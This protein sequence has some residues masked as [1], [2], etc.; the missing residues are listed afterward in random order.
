M[1]TNGFLKL[2]IVEQSD[3]QVLFE[4]QHDK[5]TFQ[6]REDSD[7]PAHLCS[8]IK[9]FPVC[10]QKLGILGYLQCPVKAMIRM[11]GS[12]RWSESLLGTHV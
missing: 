10:L 12:V 1:K 2:F 7:Q 5:F 11:T 9:D 8:L 6:T 3:K 4:L